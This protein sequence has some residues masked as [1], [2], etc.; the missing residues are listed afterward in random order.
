MVV[1]E[2]DLQLMEQQVLVT[3]VVEVV[4]AEKLVGH[5][6]VVRVD[7]ETHLQILCNFNR[8]VMEAWV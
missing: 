5:T 2:Q 4:V 6:V 3:L 1:V 8:V 7:Q